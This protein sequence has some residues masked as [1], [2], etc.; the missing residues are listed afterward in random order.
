MPGRATRERLLFDHLV[1]TCEQRCAANGLANVDP[2]IPAMNARRLIV[3]YSMTASARP[4]NVSGMVN[5]I[6]LAAFKLITSSC[7]VTC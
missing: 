5:P 3:T 1:G 7:F 2:A 4:S 6:D